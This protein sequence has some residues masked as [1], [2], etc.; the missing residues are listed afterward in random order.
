MSTAAHSSD[1]SFQHAPCKALVLSLAPNGVESSG[2]ARELA[3]TLAAQHRELVA[4][5]MALRSSHS[6]LQTRHDK[7]KSKQAAK[8]QGVQ[9]ELQLAMQKKEMASRETDLSRLREQLMFQEQME[10]QARR[11]TCPTYSRVASSRDGHSP[12]PAPRCRCRCR[13]GEGVW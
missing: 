7:Q 5:H 2:E 10:T 11:T 8:L 4:N 9:K 13:C 6:S 1:A 12:W 3:D